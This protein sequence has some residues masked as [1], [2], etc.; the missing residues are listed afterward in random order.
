MSQQDDCDFHMLHAMHNRSRFEFQ[1]C[2]VV[3]ARPKFNKRGV[4]I[5]AGI[6]SKHHIQDDDIQSN[7]TQDSKMTTAEKANLKF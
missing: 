2:R 4:C 7:Q 5:S 3:G 6:C 1:A